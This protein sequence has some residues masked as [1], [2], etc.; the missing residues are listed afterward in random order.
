ML[1]IQSGE[2]MGRGPEPAEPKPAVGPG[3]LS[4]PPGSVVLPV[5]VTESLTQ[6]GNRPSL[7]TRRRTIILLRIW[8]G[9]AS[10]TL[11]LETKN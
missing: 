4:I 8:I 11:L 10:T 2:V 1:Q 3:N 7:G 6:L 5:T 9:G